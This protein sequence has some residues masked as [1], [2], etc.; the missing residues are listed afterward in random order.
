M[1]TR[2]VDSGQGDERGAAGLSATSGAKPVGAKPGDKGRVSQALDVLN[3]G[4]P[5][6][7]PPLERPWRSNRWSRVGL[8]YEMDR[9]GLFAGD[10]AIRGYNQSGGYR[11]GARRG[12]GS[13]GDRSAVASSMATSRAGARGTCEVVVVR[14]GI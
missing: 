8:S 1:D 10:V 2:A 3:Q 11:R 13:F 9:R 7:D 4:W 14:R 5:P 12:C 6:A